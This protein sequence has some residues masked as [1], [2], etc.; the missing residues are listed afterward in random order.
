MGAGALVFQHLIGL[1]FS[2]ALIVS[3]GRK[4]LWASQLYMRFEPA[5]MPITLA[6]IWP[7]LDRRPPSI[8]HQ[9]GNAKR[10]ETGALFGLVGASVRTVEERLPLS[11]N[12][13]GLLLMGVPLNSAASSMDLISDVKASRSAVHEEIRFSR[14]V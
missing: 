13:S 7:D 10:L 12:A 14:I 4:A 5:A 6:R 8:V 9:E 2:G 1:S 3:A 11:N